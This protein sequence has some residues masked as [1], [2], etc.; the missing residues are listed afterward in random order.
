MEDIE[1]YVDFFERIDEIEEHHNE[2]EAH[3]APETDDLLVVTLAVVGH[4]LNYLEAFGAIYVCS[5]RTR[6]LL[7]TSRDKDN[8]GCG[9]D[10][11]HYFI[12]EIWGRFEGIEL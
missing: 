11:A 7:F 6:R 10:E 8:V 2:V 1:Q 5:I 4:H 9:L 3:G 12:Y